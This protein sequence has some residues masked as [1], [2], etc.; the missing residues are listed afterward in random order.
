M[1][2]LIH[3]LHVCVHSLKLG[4]HCSSVPH[5]TPLQGFFGHFSL[6][7]SSQGHKSTDQTMTNII[8]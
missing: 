6:A 8:N 5:N 7:I 1:D 2:R 4:T 3:L